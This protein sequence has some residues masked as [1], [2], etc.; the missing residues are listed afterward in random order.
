ML[1]KLY[2]ENAKIHKA[3]KNEIESDAIL[4]AFFPVGKILALQF[5]AMDLVSPG[6][7]N[8]LPNPGIYNLPL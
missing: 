4:C 2:M 8:A 1:E 6:F 3:I 7:Q 5:L